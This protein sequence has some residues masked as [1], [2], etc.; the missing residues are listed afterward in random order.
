MLMSFGSAAAGRLRK[1]LKIERRSAKSTSTARSA[2]S[3]GA[4]CGVVNFSADP[5]L[6]QRCLLVLHW[7]SS[8]TTKYMAPHHPKRPVNCCSS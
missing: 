6:L 7:P 2:P 4:V 5:R 1:M 3:G 8:R